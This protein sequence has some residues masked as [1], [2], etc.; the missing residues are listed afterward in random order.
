MAKRK[1]KFFPDIL[2]YVVVPSEFNTPVSY[3]NHGV[4]DA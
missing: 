2:F 3:N 1:T 4:N